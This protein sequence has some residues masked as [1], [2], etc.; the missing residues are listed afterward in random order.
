MT[1]NSSSLGDRII[2]PYTPPRSQPMNKHLF[3]SLSTL[4]QT[5][6]LDFA[7]KKS[8]FL[9]LPLRADGSPEIPH[10]PVQTD[11]MQKLA[12][13][14]PHARSEDVPDH[15][16]FLDTAGL[17]E[18]VCFCGVLSLR[19]SEGLMRKETV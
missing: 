12:E 13:D 11:R 18:I 7:N 9:C 3:V 14:P 17:R 4:F 5:T 8:C 2:T 10:S 6:E 16:F 15:L 1:Q 19:T